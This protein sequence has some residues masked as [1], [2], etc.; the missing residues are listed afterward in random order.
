MHFGGNRMKNT[1]ELKTGISEIIKIIGSINDKNVERICNKID[2]SI[3][4]LYY[5]FRMFFHNNLEMNTN[6]QITSERLAKELIQ[7]MKDITNEVVNDI[8]ICNKESKLYNLQEHYKRYGL[9][10]YDIKNIAKILDQEEI[11]KI[12]GNY[13]TIHPDIFTTI[14]ASKIGGMLRRTSLYELNFYLENQKVSYD[15]KLL[16]KVLNT[17]DEESVPIY[18]GTL[19]EGLKLE[20]ERSISKKSNKILKKLL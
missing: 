7:G 2:I 14:S 15:K 6:D 8:V 3:E 4:D 13:I 1:N 17:L 9:S 19:F 5:L 18:K 16:T 12:V 20:K 10:P 11:S